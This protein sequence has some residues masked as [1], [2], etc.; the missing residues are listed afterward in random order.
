MYKH[1]QYKNNGEI[2][3]KN[4]ISYGN[5]VFNSADGV[6]VNHCH[7]FNQDWNLKIYQL[8]WNMPTCN[9]ENQIVVLCNFLIFEIRLASGEESLVSRICFF[10]MNL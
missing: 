4:R 10:F 8:K 5:L 7:L 9:C 3:C 2:W 1:D 6:L